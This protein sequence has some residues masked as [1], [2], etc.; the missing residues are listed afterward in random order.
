MN[1]SGGLDALAAQA[2]RALAEVPSIP[3]ERPGP[4]T[5]DGAEPTRFRGSAAD[6]LVSAQVDADGLVLSLAIDPAMHKRPLADLADAA[7]AA[8]NQALEA[9]P[10]AI[11]Y[12]AAIAQ[13]R[14]LQDQARQEMTG[15]VQ[16]IAEV[17]QRVRAARGGDR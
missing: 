15:I 3:D 9:R 14:A 12:S 10:G 4:G 17:G 6:G 1:A 8:I 13:V 11:D 2:R 5:A 16:G 7:R